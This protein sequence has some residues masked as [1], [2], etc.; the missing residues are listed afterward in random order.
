MTDDHAVAT[1][2][3]LGLGLL[4]LGVALFNLPGVPVAWLVGVGAI[5]WTIGVAG[6]VLEAGGRTL[7][8]PR[9]AAI[10]SLL[11][12]VVSAAAILGAGVIGAEAGT[13]GEQLGLAAALVAPALAFPLGLANHRTE[14]LLFGALVVVGLGWAAVWAARTGGINGAAIA[15]VWTV[16]CSIPTAAYGRHVSDRP[17][18]FLAQ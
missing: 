17:V 7:R 9:E 8:E 10:V 16:L 11:A 4:V 5:Y 2:L 6:G 13:V 15:V 18:P 14:T 1:R 12:V 3:L